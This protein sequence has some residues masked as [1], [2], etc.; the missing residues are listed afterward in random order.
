[1]RALHVDYAEVEQT[2]LNH[3]LS[4]SFV[5]QPPPT[6]NA[7]LFP[8][9]TIKAVLG[10]HVL[11]HLLLDG[12]VTLKRLH[13]LSCPTHLQ[14]RYDAEPAF[15]QLI[16]EDAPDLAERLTDP[17]TEFPIAC[18]FVCWGPCSFWGPGSCRDMRNRRC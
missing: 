3:Q 16:S 2:V 17:R 15:L 6:D 10:L 9:N 7:L 11:P 13:R 18:L 1:M 12:L 8:L 14:Q 4:H 5:D